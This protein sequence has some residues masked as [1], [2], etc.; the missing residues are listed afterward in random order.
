MHLRNAVFLLPLI[1]LPGLFAEISVTA[2]FEPNRIAIGNSSQYI[3]EVIETGTNSMPTAVQVTSLPIPQSGGLNLRSGRT[4]TSQKT[5]ITNGRTEYTITQQLI[6]DASAPKVGEYIVP[7]YQF[8]YKGEQYQAPKASLSVVEGSEDTGLSVEELIFLKAETPKQLYVGQTTPL[9]LK[10]YISPSV[11]LSGLNAFDRTADGFTMSN[12]P[13]ES[14]ESVETVN[15]RS[16]RVL[17]WP[18]SITPISSGPQNLNF[19]FTISAQIP[20]RQSGAHTSKPRSL[21]GSSIFEDLFGRAE[22]FNVYT[23]PNQI[24]V[25]PLPTIGMPKSFSGAVGSFAIRVYSDTETSQVGEPIMLSLKITGHGN[26]ERIKGPKIAE[27][28]DWRQYDPEAFFESEDP[29]Q[30]KGSK[31][32]DYVCISEKAGTL[33]LPEVSFSFFDP[34]EKKYVELTNPELAI[35]VAPSNRQNILPPQSKAQAT[36]NTSEQAAAMPAITLSPEEALLT[37]DYR[38]KAS[39][40]LAMNLQDQV[41]FHLLNGAALLALTGSAVVLIKRRR[42]RDRGDYALVQ[43]AAKDLK[44]ALVGT[45][46]SDPET[47]YRNAQDA[48]RLA[49]TKHT[50]QNLRSADLT[51]LEDR[52]KQLDLSEALLASTR[53]LFQ[54]AD[55]HRFSGQ[56]DNTDLSSARRQ[57]HT[58]L[59]AL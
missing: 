55:N 12:L 56:S 21:F 48:I 3:V 6:I 19:Q 30:I 57:L 41:W 58:I 26:F 33:K 44:T 20:D 42:L 1:I 49:A 16:Y 43:Q 54:A 36:Q 47:F 22:R 10:L 14:S 7:A 11:R 24:E 2:R 50:R 28:T 53:E 45:R 34:K 27:N 51:T 35:E 39:R 15:G 52:L 31:R 32:F 23:Q 59:K 13:E 4:S 17:S 40:S 9:T 38:P 18:M 46:Q 37:L 8:E 29:L 5:Q 25:L